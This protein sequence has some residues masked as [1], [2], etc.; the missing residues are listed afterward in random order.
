M[1]LRYNDEKHA[2]WLDGERCKSVTAVAKIPDDTWNLE[3]WQERQV[4]IGL[5]S[6]TEMLDRIAAHYQDDKALNG[7]VEEA[8]TVA[9]SGKAAGRGTAAHSIV[10]AHI[11]GEP[12]MPTPFAD[13]VV[14]K[15]TDMI[16][17][18]ELKI[19]LVERCVVYPDLLI[20]GRFDCIGRYS[21]GTLVV[22]DL[23][24]GLKAI[25]YPH[26]IA[27]QLALYA[28]APY[29]AGELDRRG[30]TAQ[31]FDMNDPARQV[32]KDVALIMHMPDEGPATVHE[33]DIAEGWRIARDVCFPVLAWRKQ[34]GICRPIAIGAR[35]VAGT[36]LAAVGTDPRPVGE[37]DRQPEVHERL[38]PDQ[39]AQNV[40]PARA[41]GPPDELG[42]ADD[43][44]IERLAQRVGIVDQA[45]IRR[46]ITEAVE[47]GCDFSQLKT[48]RTRRRLAIAECCL[49][50][51]ES[52]DGDEELVR[53]AIEAVLGDSFQEVFPTGAVLGVLTPDE[54]KAVTTL[55]YAYGAGLTRPA[56]A[57]GK[58]VFAD[59]SPNTTT[60]GA[61]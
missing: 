22:A 36:V 29:V 26:S 50:L 44:D 43:A 25:E 28:N 42:P 16:A 8:K 3:R 27:V 4:A 37:A 59:I 46:W 12:I 24:T 35:D 51:V 1:K 52:F 45:P 34:K 18:I 23:K 31:F 33:I 13:E 10:E 53:A 14:R 2:Y 9:R 32:N 21:D 40:T 41:P 54:A 48:V 57:E 61:A 5:A 11:K 56:F 15:W 39:M 7:I 55:A 17:Q 38:A 30:E 19:V 47:A 60:Q 20:A 6:A 49:A 58:P